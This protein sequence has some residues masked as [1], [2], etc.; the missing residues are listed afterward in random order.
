V[1]A[2]PGYG[3][4][5][6]CMRNH[7]IGRSFTPATI[8]SAKCAELFRKDDYSSAL[9][10]ALFSL[11]FS[12]L[13]ICICMYVCVY[14]YKHEWM[15]GLWTLDWWFH[16]GLHGRIDACMTVYMYATSIFRWFMHG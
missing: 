11:S 2:I 3:G 15:N 9:P 4:H 1:G 16:A 5:V 14:I 10:L 13:C 12:L 8:L 7:L 6:P